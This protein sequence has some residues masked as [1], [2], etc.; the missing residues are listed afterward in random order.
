MVTPLIII[1]TVTILPCPYY[2]RTA[3]SFKLRA[4][5]DAR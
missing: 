2:T 3:R 5:L 4:V 1:F